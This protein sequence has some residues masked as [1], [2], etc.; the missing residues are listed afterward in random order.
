MSAAGAPYELLTRFGLG[1]DDRGAW[2]AAGLPDSAFEE[3]LI[4]RIARRPAGERARRVYGAQDVHDF[5]RRAILAALALGPADR[6]LEIGCGGGLLLRE[7]L[8]TGAVVTGID[9]SEEMVALATERAPGAVVLLAG[10][11]QLLFPD[12][13]F[14]AVAMSV[15]FFFLDDPATVLGECRR[16]LAPGGRLAVFTTPPELRGTPAAPEPVASRGHFYTDEALSALAVGAG[17]LDPVVDRSVGQLL[18]ARLTPL[19]R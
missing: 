19:A 3:W 8:G 1:D 4:D 14:T 6:L 5:A 13:A 11:D 2:D 17:F 10:A 15:V 16:V 12:A 9:H 7:A 18:T